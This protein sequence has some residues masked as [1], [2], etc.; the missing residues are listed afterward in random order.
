MEGAVDVQQELRGLAFFCLN[1]DVVS[2]SPLKELIARAA[3]VEAAFTV[4]ITDDK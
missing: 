3:G 2:P 4:M 1:A